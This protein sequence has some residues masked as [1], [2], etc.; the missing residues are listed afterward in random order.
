MWKRIWS[1]CLN[2]PLILLLETIAT[3]KSLRTTTW[4]QGKTPYVATVIYCTVNVWAM[5][6][7]KKRYE[8]KSE[9]HCT[10]K[11]HEHL[12]TTSAGSTSPMIDVEHTGSMFCFQYQCVESIC[13]QIL[14]SNWWSSPCAAVL[15]WVILGFFVYFRNWEKCILRI[16][17]RYFIS[18][19]KSSLIRLSGWIFKSHQSQTKSCLQRGGISIS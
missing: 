9:T 12:N 13:K 5:S 19:H 15:V 11:N 7:A 4:F 10:C 1:I 18:L 2:W 3:T 14:S 6:C 8:V 17:L 16:L